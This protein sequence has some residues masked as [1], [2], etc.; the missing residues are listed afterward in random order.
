MAQSNVTYGPPAIRTISAAN[1]PT[2]PHA[3]ATAAAA[4]A[5]GVQQAVNVATTTAPPPPP[6]P[7]VGNSVAP[8]PQPPPAT[9]SSGGGSG[10]NAQF[11][12][13]KVEDALSYLDQVKYKF[14]NQP[15]VYNDFL[16]IM[17]E[18]K[19]QSIDT[20]GVIA[21]VS[22][23]FK[24]HPELFVGFNTF[25]PPGYKIEVQCNESVAVSMPGILGA[26]MQTIVHT[27]HG[28]HTMGAHGHMSALTT[29]PS[30]TA[31]TLSSNMGERV[32][33][34]DIN[35]ALSK[36]GK[37]CAANLNPPKTEEEAN[38]EPLSKLGILNSAVDIIANLN[39]I[40]GKK[41][42]E[43]LEMSAAKQEEAEAN[44]MPVP[45]PQQIRHLTPLEGQE[46]TIQKQ[47]NTSILAEKEKGLQCTNCGTTETTF[48]RR[49]NQGEPLCNACGLYLKLHGVRIRWH[50]MYSS[51]TFMVRWLRVELCRFLKIKNCES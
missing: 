47:P 9:P 2:V 49:N 4:A 33:I 32:R 43:D 3:A 42:N 16:D 25:L 31:S 22:C 51:K 35:E 28:T 7:A 27:P 18:F 46:I 24:G 48:W 41:G 30:T 5:A 36:L 29:T 37:V 8:T 23:L 38:A 10:G 26:G 50:S 13:L 44:L 6:P 11:Q 14:G 39:N 34:R 15:Q 45:D 17:K 12:R 21:R 1:L 40:S 20:P 19:S